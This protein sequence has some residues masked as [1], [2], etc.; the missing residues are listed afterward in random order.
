[1]N[2]TEHTPVTGASL[3]DAR[4]DTHPQPPTQL[5]RRSRGRPPKAAPAD[6][7]MTIDG[8]VVAYLDPLPRSV[9]AESDAANDHLEDDDP[10]AVDEAKAEADASDLD[11][12]LRAENPNPTPHR[13]SK[14]WTNGVHDGLLAEDAPSSAQRAMDLHLR[15]IGA[16]PN[17]FHQEPL[18]KVNRSTSTEQVTTTSKSGKTYQSSVWTGGV[19]SQAAMRRGTAWL[20]DHGWLLHKDRGKTGPNRTLAARYTIAPKV[21]ELSRNPLDDDRAQINEALEV[22]RQALPKDTADKLAELVQV[23]QELPGSEPSDDQQS[24]YSQELP[25]SGYSQK[26]PSSRERDLP[27][28][29][30]SEVEPKA[31]NTNWTADGARCDTCGGSV[32]TNPHT[33][34]PNPLCKPCYFASLTQQ[35]NTEATTMDHL[36]VMRSLISAGYGNRYAD[37]RSGP[38]DDEL[39]RRFGGDA[40]AVQAAQSLRYRFGTMTDR[41]AGPAWRAAYVE[42]G[43]R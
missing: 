10:K 36:G 17:T 37:A 28:T 19:L 22:L 34:Q 38:D 2:N 11:A 9:W 26:H 14:W 27:T 5:I 35:A 7:Q 40:A 20:V 29:R 39:L 8:E 15:T 43:G 6:G 3:D 1:M 25:G 32:Q 30:R 23:S 42:A 12:E 31:T 4:P 33:S 16:P 13:F 24:G 18:W 41:D 21:Y